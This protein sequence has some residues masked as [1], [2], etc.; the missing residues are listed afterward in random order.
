MKKLFS[1]I[2]LSLCLTGCGETTVS[3]KAS[4]S[5]SVS[6]STNYTYSSKQAAIVPVDYSDPSI[7]LVSDENS[8]YG[9]LSFYT[10][11]HGYGFYH[12]ST[13]SYDIP[14]IEKED[15]KNV[16]PNAVLEGSSILPYRVGI[17]SVKDT[18][19][20]VYYGS[21]I[22]TFT[23]GEIVQAGL[24]DYDSNGTPDLFAVVFGQYGKSDV[25]EF[26]YFDLT[27][28]T[29]YSL[30]SFHLGPLFF[31]EGKIRFYE[32]GI[33]ISEKKLFFKYYHRFSCDPLADDIEVNVI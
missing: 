25:Y 15:V 2:L 10:H 26:R 7:F 31:N 32:D 23:D 13:L 6:V 16:T 5:H 30:T 1:L 24:W 3:Y 22:Y 29:A 19:N 14:I 4:K 18:G 27:T 28:F 11:L 12:N 21:R 8:D 17:Y 20:F 9:V 33:Y